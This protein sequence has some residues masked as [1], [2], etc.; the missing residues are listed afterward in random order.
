MLAAVAA[1]RHHYR[2]QLRR[3]NAVPYEY[4]HFSFSIDLMPPGKVHR[5]LRF[6][7]EEIHRLVPLLHL[8][9]VPHRR[10]ICLA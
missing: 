9:E 8:E 2:H 10:R 5:L 3:R 1:L 4:Q 6:S 7:V